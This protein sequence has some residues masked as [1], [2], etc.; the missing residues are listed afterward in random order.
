MGTQFVE[1]KRGKVNYRQ[2]YVYMVCDI[3]S[4]ELIRVEGKSIAEGF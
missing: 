3:D 1:F 4:Y 2:P